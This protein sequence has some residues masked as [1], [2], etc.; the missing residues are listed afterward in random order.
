M[1][2]EKFGTRLGF[3]LVSAGCAIGLGNVWRFPYITGEYGGAAFVLHVPGVPG[4]LRACRSW[5][6]SSPS[7]AP[8]S[9]PSR[10]AFDVLAAGGH[11]VALRSSGWRLHRLLCCSMMFYTTV[12]GW[13]LAFVAK[14]R[15]GRCSMASGCSV[16]RRQTFSTAMLADPVQLAV[17]MLDHRGRGRGRSSAQPGRAEGRRAR[18]EGH[19]DGHAV[20]GARCP[21]RARGHAAGRGRGPRVS[22]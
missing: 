5:S 1:E 6:W 11:E 8:A 12:G 7:A 17:Y 15:L 22:T 16:C 14:M 13:M 19:D 9:A 18:H 2:R 21:V 3:I 20:R 10:V 4:H